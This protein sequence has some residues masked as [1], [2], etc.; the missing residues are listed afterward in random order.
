MI[1]TKVAN[2]T[3]AVALIILGMALDATNAIGL[4]ALHH[5]AFIAAGV[6]LGFG[7]R[8]EK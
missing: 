4:Q 3:Y 5:A 6:F 2:Y 7:I 1:R 8:K